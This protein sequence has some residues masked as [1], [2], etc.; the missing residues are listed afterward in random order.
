MEK[1]QASCERPANSCLTS[2]HYKSYL[3]DMCEGVILEDE[4]AAIQTMGNR[5]DRRFLDRTKDRLGRGML[6]KVGLP[7]FK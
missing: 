2:I 6:V 5:R 7:T 4:M 1:I 3:R